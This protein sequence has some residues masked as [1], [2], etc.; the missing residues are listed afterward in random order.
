MRCGTDTADGRVVVGGDFTHVH[1]AQGFNIFRG[2]I[3]RFTVNGLLDDTFVA[4]PGADN[5]I[6]AMQ[7]QEPKDKIFIGGAFTAYNGEV[8]NYVARLNP[9]GSVDTTFDPKAG[10]NGPVYAFDWNNYIRR[11]R[12]VGGFTIYQNVSRPRIA[13][14]FAS[15]GSFAPGLLLLLND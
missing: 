7:R 8:R 11:V 9:N 4:N 5:P 10:A 12:I 14:L 2:H 6:Y 13:Q 15:A 3:A 1:N